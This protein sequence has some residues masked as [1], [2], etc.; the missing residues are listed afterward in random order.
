MSA[1][2]DSIGNAINESDWSAAT[3]AVKAVMANVLGSLDS[4]MSVDITDYFN[5]SFVPDMVLRWGNGDSRDVYLRTNH[6]ASALTEDL[7]VFGDEGPLIV[8]LAPFSPD[9]TIDPL[10]NESP[11]D[12]NT[13]VADTEG[14]TTIEAQSGDI[15]FGSFLSNSFV[16]GAR[17]VFDAA[18]SQSLATATADLFTGASLVDS[19]VVTRSAEQLDHQLNTQ[20]TS[21]VLRFG[22]VLWE[23]AGGARTQFPKPTPGSAFTQAE[24]SY[25]LEKGPVDNVQFWRRVGRSLTLETILRDGAT[26]P[27]ALQA[28]IWAN[29]DRIE[30]RRL[31]V[32]PTE[33]QLLGAQLGWVI[34]QKA[35]ELVGTNFRAQLASKSED[36][37]A[38]A[39]RRPSMAY[40]EFSARLGA[41]EADRIDLGGSDIDV[42]VR[43]TPGSESTAAVTRRAEALSAAGDRVNGARISLG[44]RRINVSLRDLVASGETNS[45][46]PADQML[47]IVLPLLWDLPE[48]D[49]EELGEKLVVLESML[50]DSSIIAPSLFEHLE[51]E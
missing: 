26:N 45:H 22:Q 11:A 47:K 44:N 14:I 20:T 40:S 30:V 13:A 36:T 38:L 9:E 21:D 12:D 5:H 31:A 46:Y 41:T 39:S 18:G 51:E 2:A 7:R 3:H 50:P 15:E 4:T 42:S 34:R 49:R 27:P 37:E 17:G 23:A 24:M 25:L 1:L 19:E 48:Q 33:Q 8:G 16:R 35:L 6:E 10:R 28:A 29:L 43:A 32:I